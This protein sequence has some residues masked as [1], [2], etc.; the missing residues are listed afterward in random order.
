M[1][2]ERLH[3]LAIA[4]REDLEKTSLVTLLQRLQESLQNQVNSPQDASH[5]QQ[6]SRH[7]ENLTTALQGAPSH[8]YPPIWKQLLSELGIADLLGENV[9]ATVRE[10]F[11]RNQITVSVALEEIRKLHK[12]VQQLQANIAALVTSLAEL[13]IGREQ[14][15]PSEV[16]MGVLIPRSAVENQL[17]EFSQELKNLHQTIGVF[18]EIALGHREGIPIRAIAS[19]DLMVSLQLASAVGACLA[20]ALERIV[21][22]YKQV[23][24]IRKLRRELSEQGV[25]ADALKR[26]DEHAND[27]MSKGLEPVIEELLARSRQED[28]HRR[29]ELANELRLALNAIANRIDRGYN[30]DVRVG[31]PRAEDGP[32][33]PPDPSIATI[34]NAAQAM[35]FLRQAGDPI[36][37][38][39]EGAGVE[40]QAP[41]ADGHHDD[42]KRGK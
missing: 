19:S 30:F 33:A 32:P 16:E 8:S 31:S 22:F 20:L 29:N 3:A 14:L 23:L 5:Q 40:E 21:G 2:A 27:L 9:L 11:Q 42:K 35:Q 17:L 34:R 13:G 24:E 26:I 4:V 15:G 6:T 10:I 39:P 1:N 18:S 41:S 28:S 37:R 12:R 25:P 7:L 36:L 38:L